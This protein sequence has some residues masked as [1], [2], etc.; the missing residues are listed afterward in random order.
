MFFLT[1]TAFLFFAAFISTVLMTAF[2]TGDTHG[3]MSTSVL[4]MTVPLTSET[5]PWVWD[6]EFHIN[7]QVPNFDLFR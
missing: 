5:P 2:A 7:F 6:I 1:V 4:A 3:I